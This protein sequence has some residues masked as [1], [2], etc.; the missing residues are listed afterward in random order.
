MAKMAS[1]ISV[2]RWRSGK[3]LVVGDQGAGEVVGS[4]AAPGLDILADE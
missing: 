3:V 2:G 4:I 1:R